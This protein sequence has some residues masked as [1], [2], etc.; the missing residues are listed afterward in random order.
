MK[1]LNVHGLHS[2]IEHT[3]RELR[4]LD[5]ALKPIKTAIKEIISLDDALKGQAGQSIR[6]FFLECHM[7]FLLLLEQVVKDYEATL[8]KAQNALHD[9][10]PMNQGFIQQEYLE[11]DVER[12][13]R[14]L[15]DWSEDIT[16]Q[17]N[18]TIATV[19]DLIELPKLNN[20][21]LLTHIDDA[22]RKSKKT[23]AALQ[24]FDGEQT[25]ALGSIERDLET[26][27]KYI[28]KIESMAKTG[29]LD[30]STYTIKQL[31][32]DETYQ[33]LITRLEDKMHLRW[34]TTETPF[35]LQNGNPFDSPFAT[36][37]TADMEGQ[38]EAAFYLGIITSNRLIKEAFESINANL[39]GKI[40]VADEIG[41]TGGNFYIYDNG[42]IVRE[43]ITH[44]G[45]PIKPKYEIVDKIP[46]NRAAGVKE[47][48]SFF[49]GTPLAPIE[50]LGAG[51]IAA[52]VKKGVLKVTKHAV[53]DAPVRYTKGID[54]TRPSWRQSEIDVGKEYPGY[55]DQVSFKDRNEVSHGTK[56]SSRPDFYINGHSIE[57]KNYKVTTSS[58]RSNLIRNVSKQINKR[59]SDLPYK[60]KQSVII[61][62]RGQNVTRDVLRDIKQK[63][64]G[65]TNGVAEIIFKMD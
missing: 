65:R 25:R 19:N 26:L 40:H 7:P 60:T 38:M 47:L 17:V 27:S 18:Q 1:T 50:Y 64:N 8:K 62:V 53:E 2:S 5:D 42:L 24:S 48:D 29:N 56:N 37:N 55:R 63:I 58:G 14:N 43:K 3:M 28:Q 20:Q 61:D 35:E 22:R 59:I 46:P 45:V 44:N 41:D 32:P 49:E 51:G 39:I 4:N 16:R 57:V 15:Q 10:E 12:G 21:H 23:V 9:V 6:S 31:G 36:F 54:K 33:Q 30:I 13:L 11:Q 52:L 34:T